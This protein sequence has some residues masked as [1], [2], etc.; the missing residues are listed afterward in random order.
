M[1]GGT[2]PHLPLSFRRVHPVLPPRLLPKLPGADLRPARLGTAISPHCDP[3][4]QLTCCSLH[5]KRRSLHLRWSVHLSRSLHPNISLHLHQIVHLSWSLHLS[6]S[7]HPI[8]PIHLGQSV[9]P[10]RSLHGSLHPGIS[11][12]LQ[13]NRCEYYRGHYRLHLNLNFMSKS[14]C[15][16]LRETLSGVKSIPSISQM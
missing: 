10:C 8:N 14:V 16:P 12:D 7:L 3:S 15:A 2:H 4:L 5:Y 9:Q 11:S 1:A 6:R 13:E